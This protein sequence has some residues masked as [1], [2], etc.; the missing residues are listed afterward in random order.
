VSAAGRRLG[1]SLMIVCAFGLAGCASSS[2]IDESGTGANSVESQAPAVG[3]Q[4]DALEAY[5]EEAQPQIPDLIKAFDGA[6]SDIG[7]E[8][9]PPGTVWYRYVYSTQVKVNRDAAVDHLQR[10]IPTL[11]SSCDTA[12]F[13]DM[14]RAG[15]TA[16]P[17]ARFTYFNADRS[18]L[19]SYTCE[20]S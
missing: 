14:A 19:W 2:E 5:V 3:A 16:D 9:E 6:F 17:R 10:Q 11:Q 8:A 7:I 13:P 15:I 1:A 20:P 12:I 18:K 4:H